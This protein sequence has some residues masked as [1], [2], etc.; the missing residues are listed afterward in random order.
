M[1]ER[2]KRFLEEK[3]VEEL[4]LDEG[5]SEEDSDDEAPLEA[6]SKAPIMDFPADEVEFFKKHLRIFCIKRTL[7]P[8]LFN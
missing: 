4:F 1:K 6:P 3:P 7:V 5:G 8:I 2:Q